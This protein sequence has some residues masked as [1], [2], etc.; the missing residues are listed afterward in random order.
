MIPKNLKR[1][2]IIKAI[3][4]VKKVGMPKRRSSKKFQLEY[5][6]EN[7]P[8]KY[9]ISLANKH[10]NGKI[11]NSQDFSGGKEA[12]NFLSSLGFNVV[13]TVYSTKTDVRP[14]K[15]NS[16][17]GT[18]G[19]YHDERCPKCKETIRILLHKIYGKVEKNYKFYLGTR[20]EDFRNSP[21]YD[22]L[23]AINETLQNHRGFKSFVR[24]KTL[25]NCDF[26]V[27]NP[28]FIVEFDESQHFTIPR[29]LTL[30]PYPEN[31][32]LGFDGKRWITLC[33]KIR[34]K[35]N[36]PPY[37][38]EQRAWYDTLRDF[39]PRIKCL[40]PTIRLYARDFVWCSL[41]P[42]N[43]L[44]LK[45]FKDIL[46]SK[47][48]NWEI[49]LT[50]DSNPFL[51]RIIIADKW[52]GNPQEAK[53]LL[54][55]I[56]EKWPEGTKVKFILTCGGFLQFDW[57]ESASIKNIGDN[58]NP[59]KE[60]IA[61]LVKEANKCA[62]FVLS[63]GLRRKLRKF[64]DYITFGID[65]QNDK[66]TTTKNYISQPHIELVF[67]IDLRNNKYYWTGKSYPTSS[68]QNSLL[69]ISNLKKHFLNLDNVRLMILGCH[70]LSIFNP[71][72]INAKGW[73]RKVNKDFKELSKEEKPTCVLQHPHTTVKVRTWLNAWS[74]LKVMLPSVTQYYGAGRFYESDRKRSEFDRLE[75]VLIN[76][77]LGKTL[78]I[79]V[80][81]KHA[82]G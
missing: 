14:F 53:K 1:E 80:R 63:K 58:I 21:Y 27:P 7:F 24:S 30:E 77:K 56:C 22:K 54:E 26:F 74:N 61:T 11:L 47:S 66:I 2:H 10:I 65:S 64:A 15:G 28:G 76:T 82:T 29:K 81:V 55:N 49:D 4:E 41:N 8:P 32:K 51:A 3:E 39:L 38:D 16:E 18:L 44:D 42:N 70:D 17:K 25:P 19:S 5:N 37:R 52:N 36:D 35:D 48:E 40:E 69:R 72:S 71:R 75:D 9:I 23:K 60:V 6:G 12:N 34:A 59:N 45:R 33:E 73:R 31:L 50:K 78:D 43:P 20:P 46:K 67:L 79:I 62:R 57:P 13:K 68:Q